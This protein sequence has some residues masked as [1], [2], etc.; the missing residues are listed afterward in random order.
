[1]IKGLNGLG[2]F[3][4]KKDRNITTLGAEPW[5]QYVI[6][7]IVD[8]LQYSMESIWVR[9]DRNGERR[10][11]CGVL[12]GYPLVML[13]IFVSKIIPSTTLGILN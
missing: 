5:V 12:T 9:H 1:M 3:V 6:L 10:L 13:Q 11:L 2:Y 4:G 8:I 7:R